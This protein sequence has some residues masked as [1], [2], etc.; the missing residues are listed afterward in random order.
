MK[1]IRS[2]TKNPL[3]IAVLL[4]SFLN[5]SCNQDDF[6]ESYADHSLSDKYSGE[7]FL[8]I[9]YYLRIKIL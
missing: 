1:T 6:V 9:L 4:L 2:I 5:L 8:E 7:E 3:T